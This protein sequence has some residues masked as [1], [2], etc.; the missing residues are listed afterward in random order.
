MKH[1]K[2]A[3]RAKGVKTTEASRVEKLALADAIATVKGGTSSM[4]TIRGCGCYY[5]SLRL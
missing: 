5:S 4:A 1:A 3:K 2:V